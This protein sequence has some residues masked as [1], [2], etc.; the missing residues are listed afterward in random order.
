MGNVF[1]SIFTP[2]YNRLNTLKKVYECLRIQ[3]FMDFEW[4][5]VDDGSDDGTKEYIEGLI[6]NHTKFPIRLIVQ[7]NSGKHIAQNKAVDIAKGELFIPLDSDDTMVN[8]ALEV[9]H[10]EWERIPIKERGMYSG[11][12]VH[13]MDS[14]GN[15]IGSLW[16]NGEIVSNDLEIMFKYHVKGEKWGTIRTDLLR[17]YKNPEV[18]GHFFSEN[19]VWF[20]IAKNYKKKYINN[21]LR[22]YIRRDDSVQNNKGFVDRENAECKV[23]A[24]IIYINEFWDWFTRYDIKFG[25]TQVLLG[26]KSAVEGNMN[27]VFGNNSYMSKLKPITSKMLVLFFSPYKIIYHVLF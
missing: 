1:F 21:M 26:V 10:M 13:C 19:T 5:V 16:P 9:F 11:I 17:L 27:I 24:S 8:N 22:Y 23:C 3:S 2:T 15:L 25:I 18:K 6:E 4:I 12:G 14:T 20:R 7:K